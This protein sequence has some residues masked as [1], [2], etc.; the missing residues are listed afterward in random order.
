MP[1]YGPRK[2]AT[3]QSR[4]RPGN[5]TRRSCAQ[6]RRPPGVGEGQRWVSQNLSRERSVVATRRQLERAEDDESIPKL[7]NIILLRYTNREISGPDRPTSFYLSSSADRH[8]P[9][10]SRQ[11][12]QSGAAPCHLENHKSQRHGTKC[13][14]H[15]IARAIH[16]YVTS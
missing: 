14:M 13:I 12:G 11:R 1:R 9:A 7:C 15:T 6:P 16:R 4:D 10:T 8:R 3:R 5:P 2:V